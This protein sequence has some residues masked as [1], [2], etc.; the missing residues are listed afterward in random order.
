LCDCVCEK[1]SSLIAS[2]CVCPPLP[3]LCLWNC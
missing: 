1:Y 3:F 2:L